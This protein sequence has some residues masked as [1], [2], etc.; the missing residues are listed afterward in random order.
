[1]DT[2]MGMRLIT[3]LDLLVGPLEDWSK[4]RS[5]A[6]ARRRRRCGHHQNIRFYHLPDPQLYKIPDDAGTLL[7][8]HPQT[9]AALRRKLDADAPPAV[10][11]G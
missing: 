8:G 11:E 3:N 9:I 7:V 4:V 1:M 6:R 2:L 5:P 10:G